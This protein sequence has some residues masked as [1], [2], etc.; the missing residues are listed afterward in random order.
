MRAIPLEENLETWRSLSSFAAILS[1]SLGLLGVLL[2]SIGVYGVVS[3]SVGNR[4]HE[5][6]IRTM[7]GASRHNLM[8]MLLRQAL[9]PVTIGT[10]V[11]IIAAAAVSRILSSA[12]FGVSPL[13]PVVFVTVPACLFL[14][15]VFGCLIPVRHVL[16]QHP[17]STLRQI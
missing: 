17:M 4:L 3:Y 5:V 13:N 7:L 2:A 16:R 6:S 1:A 10:V 14:V 11:G 8:K 9:R 12:L 15:A